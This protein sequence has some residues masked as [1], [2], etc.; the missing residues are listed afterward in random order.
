MVYIEATL[1]GSKNLQ[2]F[3]VDADDMKELMDESLRIISNSMYHIGNFEIASFKSNTLNLE[4]F[5]QLIEMKLGMQKIAV[6]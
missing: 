4:H 3:H 1:I 5:K 2:H 6:N